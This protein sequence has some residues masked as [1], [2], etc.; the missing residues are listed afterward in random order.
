VLQT[1]ALGPLDSSQV[2][3]SGFRVLA[4]KNNVINKIH[5]IAA[6][7][8]EASQYRLPW[9]RAIRPASPRRYRYLERSRQFNAPPS[10]GAPSGLVFPAG[11]VCSTVYRDGEGR[12]HELW[13]RGDEI[14]ANNLTA[15]ANNAT[16]AAGDPKIYVEGAT[17]VV[18]YRS[19]DGHVH[20]LYWQPGSVVGHDGLSAAARAPRA[21]GNPVGY[22][23]TDGYNH[24]IYRSSDG[25]LHELWWSG[26]DSPGHGDL[27]ALSRTPAAVGDPAAFVNT[28]TGGNIVVYRGADAHIHTLYWSFGDIG[29]DNLS[30]FARSPRAAGDPAAYYTRHDDA[31]QVTYRGQDGHIHEL[32]WNGIEPVNHWDLSAAAGGAPPA[33]S[34]PAV[35]YSAGTNTKHVVYRSA[36]NHLIEIWWFP[37]GGVPAYVDL[38]VW[39]LA[40]LAADKPTAFT[41]DGPNSQHVVYRGADGRVHEIRWH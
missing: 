19:A 16:R 31:H 18:L 10:V 33:V 25:H 40:P 22:L 13:Q 36:D 39:A 6:E 15:M 38:T 7:A 21:A 35:Y 37:G 23:G 5:F 3:F 32:W 8:L 12:L 30:G 26:A 28:S 2:S 4:V 14:G 24:V 17:Q 9:E 11:G 29:H 41:V 20:S 27:T 34:D 1:G